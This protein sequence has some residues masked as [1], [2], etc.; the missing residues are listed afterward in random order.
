[1]LCKKPTQNQP[2][3]SQLRLFSN[4]T[5][6]EEYSSFMDLRKLIATVISEKCAQTLIADHVKNRWKFCLLSVY[7]I[8]TLSSWAAARKTFKIDRDSEHPMCLA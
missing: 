7:C 3:L 8:K 4:I 2:L 6:T 1:M 5:S